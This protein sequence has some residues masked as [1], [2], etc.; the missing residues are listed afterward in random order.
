MNK[1]IEKIERRILKAIRFYNYR[2]QA[3]AAFNVN[4]TSSEL[5]QLLFDKIESDSPFMVCRFGSTEFENFSYEYTMR[6]SLIKRYKWYIKGW[7][8]TIHRSIDLENKIM[9][10]L[11]N[12]SGFFPYD[13]NLLARYAD[14]VLHDLPQIDI[15]GVWLQENLFN[16]MLKHV[17]KGALGALEPY[18][19]AL[20]WTSALKGK[21]VLVVHP[22]EETIRSQ[23]K[24]R[25]KLWENQEML[26]VFELHTIKAVQSIAGEK[27]PYDDWFAALHSMEEQMDAIEY[28]VAIIGCGAYG[29]HLAAHAKRMGKKAIHLGGAT[30]VLFGIKGKRWDENPAVSKYYNDYWV[31]PSSSEKP[32]QANRVEDG[33]YW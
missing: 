7:L 31:Y 10:R 3:P 14:L 12:N 2:N 18:D 29:F 9:G 20:P 23:Y 27:V 22:F 32:Q 25:D 5:N 16:E 11:C 24:N 21:K 4:L 8:P 1:Y 13:R 30:Q 15:L 6:Q 33:C 19:Y 17:R 26:P 28:D